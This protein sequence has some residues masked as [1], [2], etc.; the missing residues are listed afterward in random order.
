MAV[1][2][3]ACIVR[4]LTHGSSAIQRG[5]TTPH[6]AGMTCSAWGSDGAINRW[7]RT[8]TATA[9]AGRHARPPANGGFATRRA[10][11]MRPVADTAKCSGATCTRDSHWRPASTRTVALTW[12]C[13]C[14][15]RGSGRSATR[16]A[17]TTRTRQASLTW[18]LNGDGPVVDD[19]DGD[20]SA[21]ISVLRPGTG[22]WGILASSHA[23]VRQATRNSTADAP[24]TSVIANTVTSL[25]IQLAN[26]AARPSGEGSSSASASLTP[27]TGSSVVDGAERPERSDPAARSLRSGTWI[28]GGLGST[29]VLVDGVVYTLRD[30]QQ[31]V[32]MAISVTAVEVC[33]RKAAD[34]DIHQFDHALVWRR[35]SG[36]VSGRH[37]ASARRTDRGRERQRLDVLRRKRLHPPQRSAHRWRTGAQAGLV[38]WRDLRTRDRQQLV[39]V[40]ARRHN[41]GTR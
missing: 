31:L 12:R 28:G 19:F 38:E 8:S 20:G 4:R 17:A 10:T 7:L 11:S 23:A 3:W 33:W 5:T 34:L 21:D 13:I 2:T 36:A 41:A 16:R 6:R 15:R 9:G 35:G 14:R 40:A 30:R 25:A 24:A 1:P 27:S 29:L 22:E 37:H 32:G 26:A 39:G 18:G